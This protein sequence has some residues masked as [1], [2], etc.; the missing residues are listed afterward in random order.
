MTVRSPANRRLS[1]SSSDARA[2]ERRESFQTACLGAGDRSEAVLES[3]VVNIA[4]SEVELS[5]HRLATVAIRGYSSIES[6]FSRI[7]HSEGLV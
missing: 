6:K 5:P 2:P 7:V 4:G 3:L 1:P